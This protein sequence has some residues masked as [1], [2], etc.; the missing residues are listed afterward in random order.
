MANF[1]IEYYVA[2]AIYAINFDYNDDY[3]DVI[4]KIIIKENLLYS[5]FLESYYFNDKDF[6]YLK[7]KYR[8]YKIKQILGR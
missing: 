2:G 5:C 8:N 3:F 4:W 6:Y 7:H 1:N